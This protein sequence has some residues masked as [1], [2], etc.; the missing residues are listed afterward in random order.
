MP[1]IIRLVIVA[2]CT[3]ILETSYFLIIGVLLSVIGN[4]LH[5][6]GV[7]EIKYVMCIIIQYK[8]AIY[9]FLQ[10]LVL[11]VTELQSLQSHF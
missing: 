7:P 2:T 11:Q 1:G 6:G 9:I 4:K 3:Y 10:T 5:T 8:K